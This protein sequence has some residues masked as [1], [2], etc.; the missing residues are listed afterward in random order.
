MIKAFLW[1]TNIAIFWHNLLHKTH[2][3]DG[4]KYVVCKMV[5]NRY[6][7]INIARPLKVWDDATFHETE[8]ETSRLVVTSF[9]LR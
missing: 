7:Y 6:F 1:E 8:R 4:A 2:I 3:L 9:S 5:N